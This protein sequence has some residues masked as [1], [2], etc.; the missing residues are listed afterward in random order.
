MREKQ[1]YFLV[2]QL[3]EIEYP[4]KQKTSQKFRTDLAHYTEYLRFQKNIFKFQNLS[5]GNRLIL[6][7]GC[8]SAAPEI[9]VNDT[10]S[11]L[12]SLN[13]IL[14][15]SNCNWSTVSLISEF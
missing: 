8:F 2:A 14:S 4:D 3:D 10:N 13:F 6:K 7:F 1:N 12:V 5:L 15:E 9:E 11:L